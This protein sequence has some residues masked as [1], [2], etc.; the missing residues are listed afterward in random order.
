MTAIT[1][2]SRPAHAF[3][4][5]KVNQESEYNPPDIGLPVDVTRYE[6]NLDKD[7]TRVI[8]PDGQTIEYNYDT[9]GRT[10]SVVDPAEPKSI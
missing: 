8:Q 3:S 5:N 6:Y 7:L 2:P 4:F 1:P 10:A 9:A